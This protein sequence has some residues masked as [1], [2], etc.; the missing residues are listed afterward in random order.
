MRVLP[1]EPGAF[2]SPLAVPNGDLPRFPG[3]SFGELLPV[4]VPDIGWETGM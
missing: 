3:N 2:P 1:N 4:D